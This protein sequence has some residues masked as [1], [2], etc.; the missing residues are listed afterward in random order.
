MR[1]KRIFMLLYAF[2]CIYCWIPFMYIFCFFMGLSDNGFF[3]ENWIIILAL[4]PIDILLLWILTGKV[5][6]FPWQFKKLDYKDQYG[7]HIY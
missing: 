1:S 6:F 2:N 5:L 4:C 7:N 3:E